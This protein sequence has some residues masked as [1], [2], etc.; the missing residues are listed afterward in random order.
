MPGRA[1][2]PAGIILKWIVVPVALIA[3]GFFLIGARIGRVLPGVGGTSTP[4]TDS[5]SASKTPNYSAPDVS[6][7]SDRSNEAPE[8]VVTSR[9]KPKR[10]RHRDH[11]VP[12]DDSSVKENPNDYALP[13]DS[14]HPTDSKP[15][16]A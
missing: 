11:P 9:P 12:T 1:L 5:V 8:V 15:V 14:T 2:T 6:V 4:S 3:C 7:D 10:R 16:G 13:T